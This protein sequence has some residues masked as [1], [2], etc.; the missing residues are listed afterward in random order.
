MSC[1]LRDLGHDYGPFWSALEKAGA[2]RAMETVWLLE[3]T[4]DIQVVTNKILPH[5]TK[6]DQILVAEIGRWSATR[7]LN[8]VSAWLKT[9]QP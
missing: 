2:Q 7:L 6:E 8:D 9:R 4:Q 3:T 1:A 5:L